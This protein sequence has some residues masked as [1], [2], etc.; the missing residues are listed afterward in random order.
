MFSL[1]YAPCAIPAAIAGL[2]IV[3]A[4]VMK[5]GKAFIPYS[6]NSLLTV[7]ELKQL[8]Y[9]KVKTERQ[10]LGLWVEITPQSTYAF[11]RKFGFPVSFSEDG[12]R[13]FYVLEGTPGAIGTKDHGFMEPT[14]IAVYY[15]PD[16]ESNY[17]PKAKFVWIPNALLRS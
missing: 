8:D 4:V 10:E 11:H 1:K 16:A 15:V 5:P 9:F 12:T 13:E 3:S 17:L 14:K 2:A 6:P 7:E